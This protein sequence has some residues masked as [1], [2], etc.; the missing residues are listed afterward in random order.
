MPL[1]YL[2][3]GVMSCWVSDPSGLRAGYHGLDDHNDKH[4]P[5]VPVIAT[6]VPDTQRPP[7]PLIPGRTGVE[8]GG[9]AVLRC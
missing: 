9:E 5:G 3:E 4:D 2:S 1:F 6:D 7:P 8:A